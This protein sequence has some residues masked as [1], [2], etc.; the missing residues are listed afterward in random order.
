MP[1]NISTQKLYDVQKHLT[2][3]NHGRLTYSLITNK[4][5]WDG[6]P[7]D[8]RPGL[9]RAVK[10]TTAVLQRHRRQG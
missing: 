10:E 9:D 5:F 7:A 2:V 6:L 8:V 1:S 3:S 4:K